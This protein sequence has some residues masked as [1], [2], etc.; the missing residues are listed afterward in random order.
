M[1][2][3][4]E[5][6]DALVTLLELIW[7]EGYMTP[8]GD[9]N[10]ARLAE[11]LDMRDKRVL[12]IG[13]GIGGPAFFL[14]RE[15]GANVVG[16]DLERPL[17]ER[18][19][20]RA[21]QQGLDAKT[22]FQLVKPG[23]LSFPDESFDFVVSS[24]AFTQIA[25]KLAM[26]REVFRVLKPGGVFS[27]YDFMKSEGEYSDEMLY[28]FKMEKLTYAMETPERYGEILREAGFVDVTVE[29]CSDWYRKKVKE[30]Y[31][32]LRGELYPRALELIGKQEADHRVEDWRS[33]MVVAEK[34][35]L[36]QAYT[37][38]RKP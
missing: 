34:G 28:W 24:G 33:M 21:K 4:D 2:H 6:D 22:E 20:R 32:R 3:E 37:R 29:E 23:P 10:I 13:C 11:G 19:Q 38:G 17:V 12:D 8:G 18:C 16:T 9:R 25:N 35:E 7:G 31:E 26:F 1:S 14:A 30:E 36:R 15:Y 5:Y 27:C